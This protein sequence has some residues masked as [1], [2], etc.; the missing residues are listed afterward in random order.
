MSDMAEIENMTLGDR[1]IW[2]LTTVLFALFYI[3]DQNAMISLI[4]FATT[5]VITCIFIMQSDFILPINTNGFHSH[6]FVFAMYCLV[7]AVWA[8]EPSYAV[9]KGTTIIELL[10]CMSLLYEHYSKFDSVDQPVKAV[11]WGGFIVGLYAIYRYGFDLIRAVI[12]SSTRLENDFANVNGI[13][14]VCAYAIV[15][16]VYY[17]VNSKPGW[18]LAF[19]VPCVLVVAATGSRKA[20]IVTLAGIAL[21]IYRHY[22]GEGALKMTVGILGVV[23]FVGVALWVLSNTQLFSGVNERMQG[24]INMIT[25]SGKVDSSTR[26]RQLM[27]QVGI[28]Q[29]FKTPILGIGIGCPRILNRS[30]ILGLDAYLHNNYVELLCGGGIVGFLIYYSMYFHIIKDI[31]KYKS[32]KV[33]LSDLIFVLV[34]IMLAMDYGV[35]SYYSKATYFYLLICFQHIHILKETDKKKEEPVILT[36]D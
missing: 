1:I 36:E 25:E 35:V 10:I 16:A 18:Y 2:L 9:D 12:S 24:L 4:L 19:L 15:I 17:A 7:S 14:M 23:V 8:W 34:L 30:H 3:L 20:L 6:V 13:G 11:M 33:P 22:S 5:M 32:V 26:K 28:A 29:F 27:I 31:I 21:I